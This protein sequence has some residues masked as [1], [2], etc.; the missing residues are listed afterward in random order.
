MNVAAKLSMATAL[1]TAGPFVTGVLI[2]LVIFYLLLIAYC[3]L[4]YVFS[5]LSMYTIA[6][7]RGILNSW[8]AWIPIG[9]ACILGSISDQ[10]QYVA[11]GKIRNRRAVLLGLNIAIVAL[12]IPFVIVEFMLL[13]SVESSA[14]A[15]VASLIVILI[16]YLVYFALAIVNL[17]F[18]YIALYDLYCSCN[19]D[20]AVMFLVLG[21]FISVTQP[22]FMFACRNK[23][24]GMMPENHPET[25][26]TYCEPY[27]PLL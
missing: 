27:D 21:I 1:D 10:Y 18:Y 11:K 4:A 12:L 9:N 8:L 26:V 6:K 19:P 20:N 25:G 17:V 13:L 23:D 24:L 7:R 16:F 15:G 22:F 3:I 2:F 5:C 14:A